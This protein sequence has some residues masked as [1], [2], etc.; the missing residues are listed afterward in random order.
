MKSTRLTLI[1][2]LITTIILVTSCN[3]S[4]PQEPAKIVEAYLTA[5]VN[6]DG[7]TLSSL[8]CADWESNALM[9]LDSLQAV[10]VKLTDL[11]CKITNTDN[12][13]ITV[14]CDGFLVATYNGEDQII[15][16][17]ARNYLVQETSNGYLVCG[18]K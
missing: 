11:A 3:S 16:L 13:N 1:F 2:I 6:K 15:D 9:E 18:Y 12:S 17:S 5:L 7:A 10:D 8:S 14:T 4:M